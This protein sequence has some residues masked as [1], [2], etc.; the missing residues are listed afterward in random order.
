M[1]E[2][3]NN[4]VITYRLSR[5]LTPYFGLCGMEPVR[6]ASL[7]REVCFHHSEPSMRSFFSDE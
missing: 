1:Q 6:Q 4:T 7:T 5:E 2:T 3:M